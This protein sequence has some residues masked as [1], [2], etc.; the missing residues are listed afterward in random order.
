MSQTKESRIKMPYNPQ[1]P[2]IVQGDK[3]ILVEVN[4]GLF[5]EVRDEI[6]RFAEL[7][8]SP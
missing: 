6:A 1:N 8:K 5:E 2:L 4:N 3:T 7:E